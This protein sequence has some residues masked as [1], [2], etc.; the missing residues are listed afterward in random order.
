MQHYQPWHQGL[1]I[2]INNLCSFWKDGFFIIPYPSNFAIADDNGLMRFG[3][4]ALA[5]N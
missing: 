4:I 3:S 5:I 1:S 2:Q